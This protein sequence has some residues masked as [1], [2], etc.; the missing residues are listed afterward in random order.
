MLQGLSFT[1]KGTL[2]TSR[3]SY[4]MLKAIFPIPEALIRVCG[5]VLNVRLDL[6]LGKVEIHT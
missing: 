1:I 6:K 5:W 3:G 2:S 4:L